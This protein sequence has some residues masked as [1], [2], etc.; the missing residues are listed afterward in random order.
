MTVGGMMKTNRAQPSHI[1]YDIK[2]R[3]G[4]DTES[5]DEK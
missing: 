1:I 5:D 4:Q 2:Y 3:M